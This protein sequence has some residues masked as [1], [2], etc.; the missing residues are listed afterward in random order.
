MIKDRTG[1]LRLRNSNLSFFYGEKKDNHYENQSAMCERLY[2]RPENVS[3]IH[4]SGG[5]YMHVHA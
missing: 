1:A 5:T 3:G 4:A 2:E